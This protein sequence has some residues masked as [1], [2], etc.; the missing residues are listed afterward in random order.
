MNMT[1]EDALTY[2]R[3]LYTDLSS[4]TAQNQL[5]LMQDTI[6]DSTTDSAW[7]GLR[8][9]AGEWHWVSKTSTHIPNQG[10]LLSCPKEPYRCG[11]YTKTTAQLEMRDCD[12]M[13]NFICS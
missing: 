12:E 13:L 2:C 10:S 6:K 5:E 3:H 4:A 1:W 9:L 7:T 11:A 8:F